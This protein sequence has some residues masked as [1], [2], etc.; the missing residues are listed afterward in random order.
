MQVCI[1][2]C[3][4][5]AQFIMWG[6]SNTICKVLIAHFQIAMQLVIAWV[7]THSGSLR[8][9][10]C[11]TFWYVFTMLSYLHVTLSNIPLTAGNKHISVHETYHSTKFNIAATFSI[12]KIK[13]KIYTSLQ[14]HTHAGSW[15]PPTE[16]LGT[17]LTSLYI[18]MITTDI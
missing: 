12:L 8:W 13:D 4:E 9:P 2:R 1:D 16:N 3:T 18:I 5:S 11:S 14:P 15:W 6:A 17:R 7:V 10:L